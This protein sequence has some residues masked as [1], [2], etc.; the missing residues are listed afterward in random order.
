MSLAL[1]LLDQGASGAPKPIPAYHLAPEQMTESGVSV[2]LHALHADVPGN[3]V[4]VVGGAAGAQASERLTTTADGAVRAARACDATVG[5]GATDAGTLAATGEALRRAREAGRAAPDVPL[6]GIVARGTVTAGFVG[7]DGLNEY[8][9]PLQPDQDALITT[10]GKEFGDESLTIAVASGIISRFHRTATVLYNGGAITKEDAVN[11]LTVQNPDDHKLFVVRGSERLADAIAAVR[12]TGR[13]SNDPTIN[14]IA[15]DPRT[16]VVEPQHVERALVDHL[17]RP[18]VRPAPKPSVP[19]LDPSV[20][21]RAVHSA[22]SGLMAVDIGR[23]TASGYGRRDA[24]NIRAGVPSP[25]VDPAAHKAWAAAPK[26]DRAEA[27]GRLGH[28]IKA[29]AHTM[30]PARAFRMGAQHEYWAQHDYHLDNTFPQAS[31]TT[32]RHPGAS[33]ATGPHLAKTR[34]LGQ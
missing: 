34:T 11:A 25:L 18:A 24:L 32:A 9:A 4:T 15:F 3:V 27:L 19:E 2:A 20:R 8:A 1:H 23:M 10:P 26:G 30:S 5:Y 21:L 14:R 28:E 13:P 33:R 17:G 22:A 16:V 7:R 31:P 12:D 29:L 6:L